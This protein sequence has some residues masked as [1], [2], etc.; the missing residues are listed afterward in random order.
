MNTTHDE[1]VYFDNIHLKS[2]DTAK[3]RLKRF[4]KRFTW[5]NMLG[6]IIFVL[7]SYLKFDIRIQIVTM[8]W[9]MLGTLIMQIF[10]TIYYYK[11]CKK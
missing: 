8:I 5:F 10:N 3:M 7:S 11:Y 4:C 6:L 1:D 2:F 9:W